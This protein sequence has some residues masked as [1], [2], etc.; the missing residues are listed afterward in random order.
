VVAAASVPARRGV[1]LESGRVLVADSFDDPGSGWAAV[2]TAGYTLG[3]RAGAYTITA[4][5]GS[6]PIFA[7][8]APLDRGDVVIGA[9]VTPTQGLA[10]LVFGPDNSYRFVIS[11]S[12]RFRVEQR[13]RVLVPTTASRA[14]RAGTNRLGIAAAGR[15]VSLYANG[16]LL[17]NLDLPASLEGT[18]YGFVV[19]PG[20]RGG[21]G[22][23]DALTVR[24]LP[25]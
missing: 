13:G 20:D 8:G 6:G 12:G 16:A 25:R 3:Y 18:T 24:G 4:G 5:A 19:L 9:D 11:G 2:Q 1:A 17:A 7:F 10:G 15:R 21:A 23:F 22:L 14:L